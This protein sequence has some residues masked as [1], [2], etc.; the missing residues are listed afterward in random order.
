MRQRLLRSARDLAAAFKNSVV[1]DRPRSLRVRWGPARGGILQNSYRYGSRKILGI[2]EGALA[3][4]FRRY[5]R[6]G[7]HC[8]DI[9]AADGYWALA[10]A[11]LA[12]PGHV[13]CFDMDEHFAQ[14]LREMADRNV[15]LGSAMS[16]HSLRVGAAQ[17]GETQVSLDGL[18]YGDAWPPAN[19]IK[20]DVEGDEVQVLRGAERLLRE[21]RPRLIIEVHS[22][23]LETECQALLHGLGYTTTVVENSALA[24]ESAFRV[25]F[26]RWL[27]AE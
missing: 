19:V 23:S 17:V 8:Y 13:Y 21:H 3:P 20:V 9:G 11:R 10:C 14:P 18:V 4:Y 2:Y 25:G 12:A 1:S 26:N 6:S 7:D 15:H 27:C 5:V 24:D 22:L 16:V